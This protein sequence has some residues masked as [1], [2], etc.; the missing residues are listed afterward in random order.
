MHRLSSLIPLWR[1][2]RQCCDAWN[3]EAGLAPLADVETDAAIL[4]ELEALQASGRLSALLA[5]PR[6]CEAARVSPIA[7]GRAMG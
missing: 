6:W 5:S 3:R 2:W 1:N 7:P 4:A